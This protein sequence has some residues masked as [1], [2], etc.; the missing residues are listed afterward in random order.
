MPRDPTEPHGLEQPTELG[1]IRGRVFDELESV[2][3]EGVCRF[4]QGFGGAHREL[5]MKRFGCFSLRPRLYR[6]KRI[7]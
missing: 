3:S 1:G 6:K 2:G 7:I 5:N 4:A